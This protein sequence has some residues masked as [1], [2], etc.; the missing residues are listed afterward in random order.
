MS[1]RREVRALVSELRNGYVQDAYRDA[2]AERRQ[3]FEDEVD[4]RLK[5]RMEDRM[6]WYAGA[7]KRVYAIT[8]NAEFAHQTALGAL[9]EEADVAKEVVKELGA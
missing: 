8:K 6:D 4:K 5:Q 9:R 7:Y 2:E 3:R 1:L